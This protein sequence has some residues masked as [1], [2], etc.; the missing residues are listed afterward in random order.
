MLR[1]VA[2]LAPA[3]AGCLASNGDQ[4]M[5]ILNNSAVAAGATGCTFSGDVSQP[6]V[7]H[8]IISTLSPVPYLM[9]PLIQSRIQPQ[10]TGDTSI[11]TITLQ[12]ADVTLTVASIS[13]M[14]QTAG[15]ST[16]PA[17]DLGA[18]GKFKSLFSG[19]IMPGGTA[20][21]GMDLI[22][23]TVLNTIAMQAPTADTHVHAEVVANVTAYGTMGGDKVTS[24]PFQYPVTV[25]N[26]CVV[27]DLGLCNT[28]TMTM[29]TGDPC[30]VFQDGTVACCEAN[31]Q[32]ICPAV[33]MM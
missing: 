25:C 17:P 11:R 9:T 26:D 21:V 13:L 19:S 8:G 2:V 15:F 16:P 18:D 1:S 10:M 14:S 4:G 29:L 5:L 28:M 24:E 22:P 7:S 27:V 33:S 3:L 30:N 23:L 31:G 20:N 32:L 12:G 6:F